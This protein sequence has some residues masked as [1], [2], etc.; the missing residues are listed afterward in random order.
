[1]NEELKRALEAKVRPRFYPTNFKSDA[2]Y[3]IE[4]YMQGAKDCV[5]ILAGMG[6]SFDEAAFLAWLT[7][8]KF[9]TRG[10][11]PFLQDAAEWQHDQAQAKFTA[12][13]MAKDAELELVKK[14]RDHWRTYGYEASL[15]NKLYQNNLDMEPK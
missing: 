15:T 3:H 12:K 13:L 7:G 11:N 14:Q 5:E 4:L 8:P 1:M 10:P 6:D 9:L 2:E